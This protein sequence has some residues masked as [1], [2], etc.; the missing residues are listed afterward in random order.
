MANTLANNGI[1][2]FPQ[3]DVTLFIPVPLCDMYKI[4][5]IVV[6]E[7]VSIVLWTKDV[8]TE[9][10][11][12]FHWMFT[13][14]DDGTLINSVTE[15]IDQHHLPK[16]SVI[17]IDMFIAFGKCL[18]EMY[19]ASL[20][21]FFPSPCFSMQLFS[22]ILKSTVGKEAE[23]FLP[24]IGVIEKEEFPEMPNQPDG[25][26]LEPSLALVLNGFVRCFAELYNCAGMLCNDVDD[27]Y[28]SGLVENCKLRRDFAFLN[29]GPL[30]SYDCRDV[31]T[32]D[33]VVEW[34]DGQ[35]DDSVVY[36]ALGS[37][38]ALGGADTVELA[39]ALEKLGRPVLWAHRPVVKG[40]VAPMQEEEREFTEEVDSEGLPVGFRERLKGRIMI[41][42]WV[43]Q[44]GVLKHPA[45]NCFVT[46][47]GWNSTLECITL[48]GKPLICIPLGAEQVLNARVIEQYF[49]IGHRVWVTR[50][51]SQ[52][53]R[54][55]LADLILSVYDDKV[56]KANAKE[57]QKKAMQA[58]QVGEDGR[59]GSSLRNLGKFYDIVFKRK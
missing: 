59:H 11:A 57:M 39:M 38:G 54:D 30:S 25:V 51:T 47:C 8:T 52:I 41:E 24:G 37:W 49:G 20:W 16:P 45:I 19:G 26:E 12:I 31:T 9:I 43:N 14:G 7:N 3:M 40:V 53:D 35:T 34:L 22:N 46:H 17:A 15:Y 56:I 50:K 18:A 4:K 13:A 29:V 10:Q 58:V 42:K 28:K 36:V 21:S 5:N 23:V 33:P 55:S 44:A 27:F 6:P 32:K 1:S 2:G 48:G